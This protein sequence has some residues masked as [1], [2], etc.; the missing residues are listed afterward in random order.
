AAG[1]DVE[2][3]SALADEVRGRLEA[4]LPADAA[5]REVAD[6]CLAEEPGGR[7]GGVARVGVLRQKTDEA[8]AELLVQRGEEQRER[9]FGDPCPGRH[10][11]R[12]RAEVL[13]LDELGDEGVEYRT[14]HDD[15]RNRRF[16]G[17]MVVMCACAG[18]SIRSTT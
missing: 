12:E 13:V 4:G 8:A 17:V 15:G 3:A 16:A 2:R 6:V 7:L 10:C 11:V 14:V 5:A 1:E 18:T 9:G